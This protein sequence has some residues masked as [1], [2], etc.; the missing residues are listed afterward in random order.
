MTTLHAGFSVGAIA[1][2]LA[3]GAMMQAGLPW[4]AAFPAVGLLLVLIAVAAAFWRFSIPE[5]GAH[6]G[7]AGGIALLKQP[8][9]I[10][11][12]VA[13]I[14]SVGSQI[15]ATN[16]VAEYFVSVFRAAPSTGAYAVSVLWIGLLAGRSLLSLVGKKGRSALIIM[17]LSLFCTASLLAFMAVR[18]VIPGMALVFALGLGYSGIYPLIVTL[19]GQTFRSSAAVGMMSTAGGVAL[20]PS[21]SCWREF[22]RRSACREVFSCWR[23]CPW[24][25]RQP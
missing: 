4:R 8:V 10:L 25:L 5:R 3:I 20:S 23:C 11:L 14:C 9:V 16:W 7:A 12:S 17:V 6:H 19:A 22:R 24:A 15:G 2:P 13:M 1:G 18:A 21:R